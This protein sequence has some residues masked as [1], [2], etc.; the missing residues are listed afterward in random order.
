MAD[1]LRSFANERFDDLPD[2]M[3]FIEFAISETASPIG[4][5][6]TPFEADRGRVGH[7][8]SDNLKRRQDPRCTLTPMRRE[9][10]LKTI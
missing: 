6:Y 9:N 3:Q 8:G 7:Y 2:F 10:P 1:V 4:S 5:C